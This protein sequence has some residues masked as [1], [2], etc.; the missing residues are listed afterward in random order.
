MAFKLPLY[1]IKCCR[2]LFGVIVFNH[3]TFFRID[4]NRVRVQPFRPE[5][6]I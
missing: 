1:V 4:S 2:Q 5:F 3:I 6:L